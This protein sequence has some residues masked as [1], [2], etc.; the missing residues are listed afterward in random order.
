MA[1]DDFDELEQD[2]ADA[3]GED[4]EEEGDGGS[5][6]SKKWLWIMLALLLL[7]GG[8]GGAYWYMG[9]DKHESAADEEAKQ[10][11][12]APIYVALDPMVVNV[13]GDMEAHYLQV[14]INL[15]LTD[16]LVAEEIKLRM[17]EIRDGVLLLLSG[18]NPEEV[19][20]PQKRE[21]LRQAIL[22]LT[23]KAVADPGTKK[24]PKKYRKH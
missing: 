5:T 16:P 22:A 3:D 10:E 19:T 4:S 14:S 11:K 8:G 20:L 2:S 24:N 18:Q 21:E 12:M 7:G 17:P 23:N 15:K 13:N 6:G 9:A 1:K